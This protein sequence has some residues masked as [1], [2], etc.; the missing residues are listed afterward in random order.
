MSFNSVYF[1]LFPSLRVNNDFI[2]G[3]L[4]QSSKTTRP[5]TLFFLTPLYRIDNMLSQI[6]TIVTTG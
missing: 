6:D 1:S 3:E 4:L 5:N 2:G